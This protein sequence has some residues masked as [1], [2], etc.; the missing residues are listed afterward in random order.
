MEIKGRE[1]KHHLHKEE[2][3]DNGDFFV[4]AMRVVFVW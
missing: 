4:E 2:K 3:G 1:N